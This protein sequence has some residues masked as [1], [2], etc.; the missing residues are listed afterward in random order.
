[1]AGMKANSISIIDKLPK[2]LRV[3]IV[4]IAIPISIYCIAHYGFWSFV[5]HAIFSP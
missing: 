2:W 4:L 3:I 5:L 1:M